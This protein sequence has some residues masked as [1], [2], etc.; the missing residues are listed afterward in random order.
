MCFYQHS[1]TRICITAVE[2][3]SL[4]S[5]D[6]WSENF[7][8]QPVDKYRK[9]SFCNL[10]AYIYTKITEADLVIFVY[11]LFREVFFTIEHCTTCDSRI[12]LNYMHM[13]ICYLTKR[14]TI[15]VVFT[16]SYT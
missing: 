6:E 1:P 4:I 11:R 5:P 16:Q 2:K 7:T 9:I 13:N 10:C 15:C 8:K 3:S 12:N 14:Y